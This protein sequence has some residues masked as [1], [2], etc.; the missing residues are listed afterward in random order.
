MTP[1]GVDFSYL[2]SWRG[3]KTLNSQLKCLYVLMWLLQSV[4]WLR[5]VFDQV[6]FL[7][8]TADV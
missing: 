6:L 8:E 7:P 5:F 2:N 4:R 1:N 3:E